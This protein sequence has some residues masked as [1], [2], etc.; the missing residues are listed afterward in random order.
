MHSHLETDRLIIRPLSLNDCAFIL[1]LLNSK[2]WIK[3]IGDRKVVD[4]NGAQEYI[5][6]ILE[7]ENFS[8]NV[9]EIKETN[10]PIGVVTFL[11]RDE[12]DFPD[13]GYAMLP[14]FEK[15][16]YSF[17]ATKHYL[18]HVQNNKSIKKVIAITLPGNSNSINLL[19]KLG[20]KYESS[21]FEDQT[22]LSLYSIVF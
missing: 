9:F 6:K 13:I 22:Q 21:Y 5:K 11:Y 15:K 17:E 20:L 19:E 2:G 14:N 1:E 7:K 12:F 18:A 16:G 10:E 4:L 8:Y 3:Y